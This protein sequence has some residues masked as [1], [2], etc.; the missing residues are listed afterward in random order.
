MPLSNSPSP[1]KVC[2]LLRVFLV[3]AG[4]LL[5]L[6]WM[7]PDWHLPPGW[8]YGRLLSDV[9]VLLFL[10]VL[11]WKYWQHRR[12]HPDADDDLV[13]PPPRRHHRRTRVPG[14]PRRP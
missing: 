11:G 8:D 4:S 13:V 3:S 14:D 2:R 6:M 12:R 1:C 10:A 5:L 7:R 9:V